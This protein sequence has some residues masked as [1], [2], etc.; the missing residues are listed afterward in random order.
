[1]T[2][3]NL[4]APM[5]R[6][7]ALRKTLV[8][9][10]GL[11]TASQLNQLQAQPPLIDCPDQ[12][13]HFLA[14]GDYGTGRANQAAVARQMAEFS[15]KLG[16]PL[17]GVLALGDN[18]YGNLT[19]DRF[20]RHFEEMY[21]TVDLNCPFYACLGNHDYG[22]QYDGGQ[23]RAKAQ[24][25]LDYA[26]QNSSSRWKMPAKWYVLELPDANN[27][28]VKIIVL[29]SNLFEGALTP[30]EKVEQKR[31]LETELEKETRAPWCWMVSHY[32]VFSDGVKRDN[33]RL[34]RD[35]GGHLKSRPISLYL[36]GHDHNL[37]HLEVEGYQPS[38]VVSGAGAGLYNVKPST[39]GFAEKMLGFAHIHV[40]PAR[41]DVQF[42][43][44]EGNRVHAFR[45]MP[46][47]KVIVL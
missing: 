31:F 10:T 27:P 43:S 45:R 44:A 8:F 29:D 15:K 23:G 17:A 40:A 32:P 3:S 37:Q 11:M 14:I 26:V 41:T 33:S 20:C 16:A 1:M 9:S 34:I 21:S 4:G 39:R 47:G 19:R 7:E 25:Q 5:T 36:S 24:M 18:F 42:I 28:L 13:L 30:A 6:R 2:I 38:F 12:G 46:A 35:W 22:P